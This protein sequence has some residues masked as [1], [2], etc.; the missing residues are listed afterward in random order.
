MSKPLRLRLRI[1]K[2]EQ[3][4]TGWYM[5]AYAKNIPLTD[6]W[7]RFAKLEFE[8]PI[9]GSWHPVEVVNER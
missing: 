1:V 9:D 2:A 7:E 3:T 5:A 6:N 8:N 4:V